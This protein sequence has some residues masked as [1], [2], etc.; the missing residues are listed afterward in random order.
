MTRPGIEPR[1][2]GPLANTLTARP[3]SGKYIYIYIYTYIYVLSYIYSYIY[4]V[5]N[6]DPGDSQIHILLVNINSLSLSLSLSL[7]LS[8]S[9]FCFPRKSV[10]VDEK[11]EEL[12]LGHGCVLTDWR[13]SFPNMV[14]WTGKQLLAT[15]DLFEGWMPIGQEAHVIRGCRKVESAKRKNQTNQLTKRSCNRLTCLWCKE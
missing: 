5:I 3:M 10:E 6:L 4:V 14:V 8:P 7:F 9:P 1:S 2:P 11:S 12:N 13:S 15:R